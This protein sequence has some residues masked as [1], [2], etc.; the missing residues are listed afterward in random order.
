[1]LNPRVTTHSSTMFIP[2]LFNNWNTLVKVGWAS[3]NKMASRIWHVNSLSWIPYQNCLF[4]LLWHLV[5]PWSTYTSVHRLL[6]SSHGATLEIL[7]T[8]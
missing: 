6:T 1:L 7:Q 2:I 3:Y 4:G 8:L 5:S